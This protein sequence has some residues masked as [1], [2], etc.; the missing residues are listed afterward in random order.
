MVRKYVNPKVRAEN[1]QLRAENEHLRTETH[2]LLASLFHVLLGDDRPD[3][4]TPEGRERIGEVYTQVRDLRDRFG[5]VPP[6]ATDYAQVVAR[7][8]RA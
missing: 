6:V 5:P 7:L 8:G 4:T 2:V 3:I 1:D